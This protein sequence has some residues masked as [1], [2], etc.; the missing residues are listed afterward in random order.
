M[1]P[2]STPFRDLLKYH[3]ATL[4]GHIAALHDTSFLICF[5]RTEFISETLFVI[6]VPGIRGAL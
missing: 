3:L 5:L 2:S 1:A 4:K 6:Q